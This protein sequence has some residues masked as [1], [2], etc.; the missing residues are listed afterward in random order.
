MLR[1]LELAVCTETIRCAS[2]WFRL[3]RV[4]ASVSP[5][6]GLAMI[7]RGLFVFALG[8]S[9]PSCGG[10]K[11]SPT[12]PTPSIAQVA[13]VWSV[14]NTVS[15]VTGGECFAALFQTTIGGV[16]RGT[17]QVT[18]SGASVTAT[19]TSDSTGASC[20]YQGTAGGSSI[21]LNLVSCTASDIF[22]AFCPNST[23][24]RDVRLQTGGINAT[25][26]GSSAN[27]TG[28]E[29]YNVFVA[30]TNSGVGALIVN[31]TFSATRR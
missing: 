7:R 27:G 10:S 24:R 1:F 12:A 11:G 17:M 13:G 5:R 14:V 22:A 29:T 16:T 26:S 3:K 30:G 31:S 15:A 20:S 4:P 8:L 19:F 6:K 23:A 21:A 28:A 2:R 25:V 18:Q 9:L